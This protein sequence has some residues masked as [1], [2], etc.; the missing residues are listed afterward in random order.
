MRAP[1]TEEHI[2]PRNGNHAA[3]G[4]SHPVPVGCVISLGFV[5]LGEKRVREEKAGL[6]LSYILIEHGHVPARC[7]RVF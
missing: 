7:C 1:V 6:S 2:P 4:I 3:G 5:T